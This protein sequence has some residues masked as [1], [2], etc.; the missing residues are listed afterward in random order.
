[1]GKT[2]EGLL[3]KSHDLLLR[4]LKTI[5][6][7]EGHEGEIP[8]SPAGCFKAERKGTGSQIIRR[9]RARGIV[10]AGLENSSFCV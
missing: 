7:M 9:G 2:T 6:V 8:D 3:K 5:F 4:H 10:Y 1:M